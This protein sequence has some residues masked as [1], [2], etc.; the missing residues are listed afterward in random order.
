L[1]GPKNL[2]ADGQKA[3][4]DP[5]VMQK[6]KDDMLSGNEKF[7]ENSGRIGGF[8][9]DAG[10]YYIGEGHHRINAAMKIFEETGDA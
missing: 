2:S 6:I 8:K 7:L 5:K 9:D 3:L 10:N 4:R 1:E